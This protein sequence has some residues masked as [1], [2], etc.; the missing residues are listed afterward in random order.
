MDPGE[1][2]RLRSPA[3]RA[4]L[5][6]AATGLDHGDDMLTLAT[7]L[8]RGGTDPALVA[9][10]LTQAQLRRRGRTK[11]GPDADLMLWTPAGL[12]QSTRAVVG[13]HR[14]ARYGRLGPRRVADLCCGVG[15]DLISL[16]RAELSVLGVDNDP[17]SA[18]LALANV[19]EL[20]LAGRVQVRVADVTSTDLRGCDALFIDPARRTAG[21]RRRFDPRDYSPPFSF[22]VALADQ[23]AATGIK[24]A[25]GL[26]H[27]LVPAGA[28]AEWVSVDG[29]V[30]EAALWFGPLGEPGTRRATLL[31]ERAGRHPV[32]LTGGPRSGPPPVA[33]AGAYLHEPD[34]AVIRAGLVAEIAGDLDGW[35]LDP[36][37]AYVSTDSP[38]GSAFTRRYVVD[39]VMPFG[40]K[41]LRSALRERGVGDVVVKKR[42][43]AVEPEELRRRLRL[44]GHGP[45]RTLVLTRVGG[46]PIVL[47]VDPG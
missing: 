16:A 2:E 45:T 44:D 32:T 13:A 42:G 30:K 14:A 38:A 15:G 12:E 24:V 37:I 27:E 36:S 17:A 10:A 28:E 11:F 31:S 35:L 29:N 47:L 3:G 4:V 8:R 41:R 19:T 23:V 9:S 6:A 46:A 39:E 20:G 43:T 7:M 26:P 1:L 34:G 18:A 25:P 5:A 21:G 40:L 22:A 33:A